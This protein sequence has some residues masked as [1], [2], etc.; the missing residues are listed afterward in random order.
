MTA[1][2]VSKEPEVKETLDR[3]IARVFDIPE[4]YLSV[5]GRYEIFIY[6]KHL[7]RYILER[8]LENGQMA[9]DDWTRINVKNGKK[10][11]YGIIRQVNKNRY[12]RVYLKHNL[13]NYQKAGFR[14]KDE[15]IFF[16]DMKLKELKMAYF[17]YTMDQIAFMS[18]CDRCTVIHSISE[19]KNLMETDRIYREKCNQVI[20]KL[21]NNLLILP[22]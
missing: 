12:W 19:C 8:T 3:C 1:P 4:V 22:E 14:T 20:E 9:G 17:R 5:K 18:G 15:A 13:K 21:N 11:D 2:G 10:E 16:R 7:R 6:P